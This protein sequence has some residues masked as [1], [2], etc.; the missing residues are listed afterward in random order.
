MPYQEL[1]NF[2]GT[3]T[4]LHDGYFDSDGLLAS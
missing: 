4:Q 3:Y 1:V 2:D